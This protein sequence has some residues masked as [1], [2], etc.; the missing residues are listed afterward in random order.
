MVC[1]HPTPFEL[2]RER[3]AMIHMQQLEE[4]SKAIFLVAS[5][6]PRLSKHPFNEVCRFTP[7]SMPACTHEVLARM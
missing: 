4:F 5:Q 1:L 7:V 6:M 2:R 3:A